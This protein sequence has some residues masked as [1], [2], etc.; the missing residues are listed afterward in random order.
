MHYIQTFYSP[1]W[2]QLTD[3]PSKTYILNM[4]HQSLVHSLTTAF[5][6]CTQF[7]TKCLLRCIISCAVSVW[8]VLISA[9]LTKLNLWLQLYAIDKENWN[10]TA[11]T[12]AVL[13]AMVSHPF[14]VSEMDFTGPK[15]KKKSTKKTFCTWQDPMHKSSPVCSSLKWQGLSLLKLAFDT[16]MARWLVQ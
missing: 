2:L 15:H 8:P 6:L 12:Q 3:R 14:K 16:T 4:S 5:E 10:C 1:K 9:H 11:Y 13:M 7:R